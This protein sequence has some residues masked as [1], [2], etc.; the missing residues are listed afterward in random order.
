MVLLHVEII[1]H[2]EIQ[3]LAINVFV[4]L[5]E[6]MIIKT[7]YA[8]VR[9]T[10]KTIRFIYYIKQDRTTLSDLKYEVTVGCC[11]FSKTQNA[12]E[13]ALN[14]LKTTYLMSTL[15]KSFW[16]STMVKK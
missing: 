10:N 3:S 13:S 7:T 5:D 1:L 15:T 14:S 11:R 12:R 4:Q 6:N 2:V 8:K 16:K 9:W